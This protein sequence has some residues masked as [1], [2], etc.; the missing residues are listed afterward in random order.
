MP[1]YCELKHD[2]CFVLIMP[3]CEVHVAMTKSLVISHIHDQR[4]HCLI[5]YLKVYDPQCHVP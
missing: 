4:A 2:Q 3:Q 1:L 5:V